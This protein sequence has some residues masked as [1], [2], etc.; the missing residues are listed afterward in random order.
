MKPIELILRTVISVNQ[1]SVHGAVADQTQKVRGNLE[2]LGIWNQWLYRQHFPTANQN[3]QTDAES[4]RKLAA[5]I[6]AEIRRT[7]WTTEMDQTLLQCW[8]L[9][10]TLRK[11]NSSLHLVMIHLDKLMGSCREDTLPRSDESSQVKGWIRGNTKI[12]LVLQVKVCYHQGRYGVEIKIESWFRYRTCSWIRTVNGIKKYVTE[13]SEE[14]PVASAGE[15]STGQP[16]AKAR[17]RSTPT[18]TLV[19]LCPIPYNEGKWIDIEPGIFNQGCF[20]V[21]QLMIRILPHDESTHREEDGA[22]RFEDLASIFRSE[23]DG[24]SHCQFKL[25]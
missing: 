5:W 21:S 7:S 19:L 13:T 4:T 17:P 10:R 16:V 25:G 24:T 8:F 6:W 12:G 2:R 3:P 11:D 22:V 18:L 23:F 14:I 1:L 20:G 9:E 15:R